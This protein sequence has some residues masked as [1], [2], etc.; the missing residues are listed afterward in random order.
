MHKPRLFH[1]PRHFDDV[2]RTD[3]IRPQ[4]AL[5][6]RIKRHIAGPVD[7]DVGVLHY[8]CRF[9]FVETEILVPNIA[10]DRHDL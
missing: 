3:D 10:V 2:V 1:H 8:L 7:N 4:R 5:K 6:R 9:F